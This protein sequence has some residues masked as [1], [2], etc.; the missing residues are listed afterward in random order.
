MLCP[1][2]D[3]WNISWAADQ[4]AEA[5]SQWS[6]SKEWGALSMF[7]TLEA[8]CN[9]EW[10]GNNCAG[11][12]CTL[13]SLNYTVPVDVCTQLEL[14]RP[15]I[16][17]TAEDWVSA[18]AVCI[19]SILLTLCAM[20]AVIHRGEP[21]L[22]RLD[23]KLLWRHT[24]VRRVLDCVWG[25]DPVP[26][27]VSPRTSEAAAEM[28]ELEG[29]GKY[30][31]NDLDDKP[32]PPGAAWLPFPALPRSSCPLA[33]LFAR[34]DS[35]SLCPSPPAA[36][37]HPRTLSP[38]FSI[39]WCRLRQPLRRRARIRHLRMQPH[40]RALRLHARRRHRSRPFPS[41]CRHF[42]RCHRALYGGR[43]PTRR[44]RHVR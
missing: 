39:L 13:R 14:D 18:V 28:V 22:A 4:P 6:T 44:P 33:R 24:A 16:E 3:T 5:C 27:K 1:N 41:G 40:R 37:T 35:H 43:R 34:S 32:A 17:G 12:C 19:T 23:I 11:T 21:L 25:N 30:E 29:V 38:L 36:P 31:P 42:A 26:P 10:A 9:D 7:A 20:L 8:A 15:P 2:V